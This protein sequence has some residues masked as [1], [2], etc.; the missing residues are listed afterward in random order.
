V[1]YA[2]N[3]DTVTPHDNIFEEMNTTYAGRILRWLDTN[4]ETPIQEA[5]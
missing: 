4:R 5:A 2:I 3:E 1:L